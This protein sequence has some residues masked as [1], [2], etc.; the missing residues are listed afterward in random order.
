M[1]SDITVMG[2]APKHEILG[3][4]MAA[5]T[6]LEEELPGRLEV[7]SKR[8]GIELSY[9]EGEGIRYNWLLFKPQEDPERIVRPRTPREEVEAQIRLLLDSLFGKQENGKYMFVPA[10]EVEEPLTLELMS[11]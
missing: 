5:K 10:K 6:V 9:S 8:H 1:K 11:L 4:L 3:Q 2:Q 7:V